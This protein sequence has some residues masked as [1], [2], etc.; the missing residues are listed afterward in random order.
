MSNDVLDHNLTWSTSQTLI[1][2]NQTTKKKKQIDI[3]FLAPEW[4]T[5]S[6]ALSIHR[7]PQWIQL[8]KRCMHTGRCLWFNYTYFIWALEQIRQFATLRIWS[9]QHTNNGSIG[10]QFST[11]ISN[12]CWCMAGSLH[13]GNPSFAIDE[14]EREKGGRFF[15]CKFVWPWHSA[16]FQRPGTCTSVLSVEHCPAYLQNTFFQFMQQQPISSARMCN[17]AGWCAITSF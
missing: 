14:G 6:N 15:I 17:V 12:Q 9:Q 13:F 16:I 8:I 11:R 3:R 10:V 5:P 1:I 2:F 4:V 7:Q